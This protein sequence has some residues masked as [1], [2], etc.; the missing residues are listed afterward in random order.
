MDINYLYKRLR[1]TEA[2]TADL[3]MLIGRSMPFLAEEASAI[4]SKWRDTV[5]ELDQVSTKAAA[6]E[7][8]RQQPRVASIEALTT[9][10]G[11]TAPVQHVEEIPYAGGGNSAGSQLD[12]GILQAMTQTGLDSLSELA[13]SGNMRAGAL[14][15]NLLKDL[16]DKLPP[17]ETASNRNAAQVGKDELISYIGE[18]IASSYP[19]RAANAKP[20][21]GSNLRKGPIERIEEDATDF[22]VLTP[23]SVSVFLNLRENQF[24]YTPA[25]GVLYNR[26]TSTNWTSS[27]DGDVFDLNVFVLK[28]ELAKLSELQ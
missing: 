26:N 21:D 6:P 1:A 22:I 2:L 8:A 25:T 11:Q 14:V 28:A 20:F 27:K 23:G 15:D 18:A 9:G 3:L 24:I 16:R 7:T 10:R 19:F 4:A 5:Q 17:T 12:G 13:A